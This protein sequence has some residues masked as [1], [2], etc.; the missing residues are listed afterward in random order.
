ME[1]IL[2]LLVAVVE[3]GPQ[4]ADHAHDHG[5]VE[6]DVGHEDRGQR[7]VD[8]VDALLFAA[9]FGWAYWMW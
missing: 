8:L 4:A 5:E 6:V 7:A 2:G 3:M 9:V 1:L